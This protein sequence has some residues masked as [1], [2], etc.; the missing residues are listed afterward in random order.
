[1]V[2]CAS[3]ATLPVIGFFTVTPRVSLAARS[4]ASKAT[5]LIVCTPSLRPVTSQS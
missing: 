2:V 3:T 4:S 1:M 5:T